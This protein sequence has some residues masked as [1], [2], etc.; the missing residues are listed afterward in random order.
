M[1]SELYMLQKIGFEFDPEVEINDVS[2]IKTNLFKI[3][4][5]IVENNIAEITYV[6]D[7]ML[8]YPSLLKDPTLYSFSSSEKVEVK[9]MLENC[10]YFIKAI[11]KDFIIKAV[12]SDRIDSLFN[13]SGELSI[14]GFEESFDLITND[15]QVIEVNSKTSKD[16]RYLID[17]IKISLKKSKLIS[18][19]TLMNFPIQNAEMDKFI[20][21]K[22]SIIFNTLS[23]LN[24]KLKNRLDEIFSSRAI[25]PIYK[26]NNLHCIQYLVNRYVDFLYKGI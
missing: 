25:E 4:D 11:T 7:V 16:A 6:K 15:N 24:E 20:F 22:K 8:Y 10:T 1:K 3:V 18:F 23:P 26:I 2:A 13:D 12:R 19:E 5:Y 17:L 21:E 14:Y 9:S